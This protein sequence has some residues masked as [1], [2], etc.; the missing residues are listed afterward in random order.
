MTKIVPSVEQFR[1][2]CKKITFISRSKINPVSTPYPLPKRLL[3]EYA[4]TLDTV[5]SEYRLEPEKSCKT[6]HVF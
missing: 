3:F 6:V 5:S 1:F 2:I 4:V